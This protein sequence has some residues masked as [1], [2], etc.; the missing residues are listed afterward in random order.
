[1][2]RS[3]RKETS[4]LALGTARRCGGS[5]AGF[6]VAALNAASAASREVVVLRLL[7]EG[8]IYV[9]ALGL[10]FLIIIIKRQLGGQSG[11][12]CANHQPLVVYPGSDLG[13]HPPPRNALQMEGCELGNAHRSRT[14]AVLRLGRWLNRTAASRIRYATLF[15]LGRIN[16]SAELPRRSCIAIDSR[17]FRLRTSA[18]RVRV[19]MI[20]SRSRY[21]HPCCSMRYLIAS[22]GSAGSIGWCSVSYAARTSRRS[23]FGVTA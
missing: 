2:S 11:C 19:P 13:N 6:V 18:L 12:A 14:R 17:R 21:V 4:S 3:I 20:S 9:L 5:S 16:T 1:M 8:I 23:T 22:M 7:S 10:H 15:R